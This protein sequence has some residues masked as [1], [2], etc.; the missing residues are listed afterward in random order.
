MQ[1]AER[2]QGL[3]QLRTL[4]AQHQ[5][6]VTRLP[7]LAAEFQVL[8]ASTDAVDYAALADNMRAA[9][10]QANGFLL[11]L[12]LAPIDHPDQPELIS[13]GQNLCPLVNSA[14]IAALSAKFQHACELATQAT[15]AAQAERTRL[16]QALAQS[17]A[18][19]AKRQAVEVA[20]AQA[21]ANRRAQARVLGFIDN[22]DGTVTDTHSHLMWKQCA[23]G[24]SGE[25]CLGRVG[26]FSWDVSMQIPKTLNQRGG[27][28]GYHNWRVPSKDELASLVMDGRTSPAICTEAFPNASDQAFWSSSPRGDYHAWCVYFGGGGVSSYGRVNA[29]AVRLVRIAE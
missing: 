19:E 14:S 3:L 6:S 20:H 12:D 15:R 8:L 9:L 24:Q 25:E 22:G 28:A 1:S 11:A 23:E 17:Q 27:F 7:K 13:L 21:L 2:E 29:L 26:E 5:Q 10:V 18:A 16:A 4:L